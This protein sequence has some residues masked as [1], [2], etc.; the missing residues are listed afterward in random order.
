VLLTSDYFFTI[1][2]FNTPRALK[3][4][5]VDTKALNSIGQFYWCEFAVTPNDITKYTENWALLGSYA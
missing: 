5:A 3:N 4:G 1:L 2:H